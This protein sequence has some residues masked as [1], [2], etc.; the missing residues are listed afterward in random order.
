MTVSPRRSKSSRAIAAGR[1]VAAPE[2][3]QGRHASRA[4]RGRG[5][6]QPL[7]YP[8]GHA[9][10]AMVGRGPPTGVVGSRQGECRL[11]PGPGAAHLPPGP[12]R[13]GRPHDRP[14]ERGVPRGPAGHL[15]RARLPGRTAS[16]SGSR[17]GRA[18]GPS[19]PPPSAWRAWS[20]RPTAAT[21]ARPGR[22]ASSRT[23]FGEPVG[24]CAVEPRSN[25]PRLPP[26]RVVFKQR[27]EDPADDERLGRDLLRHPRRLPAPRHHARA[28]RGHCRLRPRARRPGAR[29]LPDDHR[30]RAG[31]HLGRDPR[32]HAQHLR[33]RRVHRGRTTRRSGGS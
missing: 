6:A 13:S 28:R 9:C 33:G 17:S 29:G 16:A 14:R 3:P 19:R 27:G 5:Q 7:E 12:D 8:S 22:A 10:L 25:Y 20:R 23:S 18:A 32:R 24:W 4:R 1:P 2:R 30:A 21:R 31:G 26:Q 15:R 11:R